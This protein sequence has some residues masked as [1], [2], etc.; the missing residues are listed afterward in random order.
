MNDLNTHLLLAQ[1]QELHSL[2]KNLVRYL[3]G[4]ISFNRYIHTIR[5]IH[6]IF[7]KTIAKAERAITM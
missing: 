2:R 7:E 4:E 6:E 3:N 5:E 1:T